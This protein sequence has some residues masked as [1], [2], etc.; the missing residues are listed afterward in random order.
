MLNDQL[1]LVQIVGGGGR[2]RVELLLVVVMVE[3]VVV[4][5]NKRMAAMMMSAARRGEGRLLELASGG[6]L[7]P[8]VDHE[9]EGA[10]CV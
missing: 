2:L 1:F 10:L 5:R 3:V 8:S 6:R 9:R 4:L 7:V